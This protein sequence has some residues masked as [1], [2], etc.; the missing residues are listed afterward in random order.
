MRKRQSTTTITNHRESNVL[1]C[2]E[3]LNYTIHWE[4][5]FPHFIHSVY[6]F[7]QYNNDTCEIKLF[8]VIYTR[9][10]IFK[11]FVYVIWSIFFFFF[12]YI[13]F[14]FCSKENFGYLSNKNTNTQ[15]IWIKIPVKFLLSKSE[16]SYHEN[17]LYHS[18]L[19][20]FYFISFFKIPFHFYFPFVM[21]LFLHIYRMN[22]RLYLL[23]DTIK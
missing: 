11:E 13:F 5:N 22:H 4:W 10:K 7:L 6:I 20:G 8:N 1:W 9:L 17:F 23:L 16:I 3:F 15:Y 2:F 12:F 14:N 21:I 19:S 18:R